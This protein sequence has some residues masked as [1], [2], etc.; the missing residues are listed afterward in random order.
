MIGRS[1]SRHIENAVESMT[2][3]CRASASSK[4]SSGNFCRL[5][6]RIAIGFERPQR[7]GRVG[8]EERA[9][10][11][12]GEDHDLPGFERPDRLFTV[13]SRRD[14]FHPDRALYDRLD[15]GG[16]EEITQAQRVHH[17]REHSHVVGVDP[18]HAAGAAHDAA[19][20][21]AGADDQRDFHA[22]IRHGFDS[23]HNGSDRIG[24]IS[25]FLRTFE[26]LAAEFQQHPAESEF[27][28]H[29]RL[30]SLPE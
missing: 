19:P 27:F 14:G 12:A 13:E 11:A 5:E 28:I 21:V 29:N 22:L 2:L 23:F 24:V 16:A 9:A 15:P 26:R 17:G 4:L 30:L 3:S 18:V 1:L 10:G 20:D 25:M 8:R 6:H 7:A